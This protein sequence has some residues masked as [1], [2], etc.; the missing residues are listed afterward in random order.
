MNEQD[1]LK[2][3][4]DLCA[5][6]V[7]LT[8]NEHRDYYQTSEQQLI[9]LDEN[10]CPPEISLDVRKTIIDTNTIIDLQFYPHTPIGSCRILHHDLDVALDVALNYFSPTTKKEQT[11]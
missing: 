5:C 4:I 10:E 6:G 2:K 11:T 7:Y 8:I 9:E 3:L 1:K